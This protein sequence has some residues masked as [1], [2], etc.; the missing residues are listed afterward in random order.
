MAKPPLNGVA[1]TE[2]T[3][4]QQGGRRESSLLTLGE[5][6]VTQ[7]RDK[8]KVTLCFFAGENFNAALIIHHMH[9]KPTK[10]RKPRHPAASAFFGGIY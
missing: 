1:E 7:K 4:S 10:K 5:L 9:P 6:L 2:Y 3:K 8:R